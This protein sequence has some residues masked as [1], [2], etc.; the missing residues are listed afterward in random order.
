MLEG[1]E[2][3][4][5][6]AGGAGRTPGQDRDLPPGYGFPPETEAESDAHTKIRPKNQFLK[7]FC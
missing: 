7:T 2:P 5:L 4:R 3:P 1:L 6:A